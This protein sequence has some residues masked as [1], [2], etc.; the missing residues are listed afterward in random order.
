MEDLQEFVLKENHLKLLSRMNVSWWDAEFGA[1]SI[2]P[3]RPYG[4]SSVIADMNAILGFEGK[5]CRCCGELLE[6]QDEEKLRN[7]HKETEIALQI[8]L[9]TQSFKP[10]TYIAGKYEYNWK[11]KKEEKK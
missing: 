5:P 1:P 8:V 2:D 9:S 4:N 11:L 10:G 3:K 6:E 7:L